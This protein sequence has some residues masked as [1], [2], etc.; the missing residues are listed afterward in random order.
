VTRGPGVGWRWRREA[1]AL[2]ARNTLVW[3]KPACAYGMEPS[4][5]AACHPLWSA[6]GHSRW[7]RPGV[8]DRYTIHRSIVPDPVRG[9]SNNALQLTAARSGVQ[10][11]IGCAAA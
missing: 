8:I 6:T 10:V 9:S 3:Q 7:L 2:T 4:G 5:C 1:Y 11:S